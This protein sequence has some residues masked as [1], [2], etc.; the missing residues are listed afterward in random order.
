MHFH[1]KRFVFD[2]TTMRRTKC[3]TAF[4]FPLSWDA[5][6]VLQHTLHQQPASSAGDSTKHVEA[7]TGNTDAIMTNSLKTVNPLTVK[8]LNAADYQYQL[9][10]VF[11]HAGGATG[12]IFVSCFDV[13]AV[14]NC[15]F[16]R[17]P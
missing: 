14:R 7:D 13:P 11:V 10:A 17:W 4:A 6:T 2:F 9:F 5:R 8:S 12:L 1:L 16:V 15:M 3:N